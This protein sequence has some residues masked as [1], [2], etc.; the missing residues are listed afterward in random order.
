MLKNAKTEY[1]NE[2]EEIATYLAIETLAEKGRRLGDG[3]AGRGDPPRGGTDG[4]IPRGPDPVADQGRGTRR[5]AGV[6]ASPKRRWHAAARYGSPR[7][8]LA[9]GSFKG[10]GL[11]GSIEAQYLRR[12]GPSGAH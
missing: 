12:T 11:V 9:L 3:E 4:E 1:F 2:H 6:G 10:S 8:R 7:L 5:G